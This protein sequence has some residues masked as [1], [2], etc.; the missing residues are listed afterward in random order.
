[1]KITISIHR[2]DLARIAATLEDKRDDYSK[3][4]T[5]EAVYYVHE[6]QRLLDVIEKAV[7]K[8]ENALA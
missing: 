6:I 4:T 1:M 2:T 8:A 7:T 3:V 5:S